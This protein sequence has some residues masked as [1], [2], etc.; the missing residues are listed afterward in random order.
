VAVVLRDDGH[1]ARPR[2]WHHSG[3]HRQQLPRHGDQRE[4]DANGIAAIKDV[5]PNLA[6][7][8]LVVAGLGIGIVGGL[9]LSRPLSGLLYQAGT[10]DPATLASAVAVLGGVATIAIY[11]PARPA[12][13]LNPIVALQSD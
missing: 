11:L 7:A 3:G 6:L 5:D 4:A 13:R 1:A 9:V 8:Q 10:G 2:S 12:S